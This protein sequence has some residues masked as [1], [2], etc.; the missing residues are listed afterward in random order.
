MK[1]ERR[2]AGRH[3]LIHTHTPPGHRQTNKTSLSQIISDER[4]SKKRRLLKPGGGGEER[5]TDREKTK[6]RQTERK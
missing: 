3:R 4:R 1:G 2:G 6:E 5:E